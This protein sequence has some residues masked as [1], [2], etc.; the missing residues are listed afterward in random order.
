MA[1]DFKN[2]LFALIKHSMEQK[3]N[4]ASICSYIISAGNG[5]W[6][7]EIKQTNK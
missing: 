7:N 4:P 6:L 2:I 5:E 3:I 1:S